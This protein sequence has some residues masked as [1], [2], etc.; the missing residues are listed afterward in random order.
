MSCPGVLQVRAQRAPAA[1]GA[2]HI[3]DSLGAT[4]E[5]E[6]PQAPL[7]ITSPGCTSSSPTSPSLPPVIGLAD[8]LPRKTQQR[9]GESF[10]SR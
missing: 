10:S 6:Q 1:D 9:M 5:E 8:P 2:E 4:G 3:G 7:P